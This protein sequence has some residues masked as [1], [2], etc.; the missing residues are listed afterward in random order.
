MHRRDQIDHAI[1]LAEDGR[2]PTEVARITGVPRSTVRDWLQGAVPLNAIRSMD[3]EC[4]R[5]RRPTHE[6]SAL[7][8]EYVYVLGLY[9]GDGCISAH[10]R[11][12]YRLRIFL[13]AEYPGII[14]ACEA[15]IHRLCPKNKV[16]RLPGSGGYPNSSPGSNVQISA[17]SRSWPCL[18]PQHGPGRKHERPIRLVDWQRSL[19]ETYPEA[20]LRGLIHSDGCRFI[21]TGRAWRHPRYAF[22]NRSAD[23]CRIFCDACDVLGLHWTTAPRTVYVSRKADVARLDEFIGPKA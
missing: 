22:N 14:D 4:G 3:G 5:C 20:L 19:L 6:F 7:P 23:I 8:V 16:A 15:A 18:F 1:R 2:T 10:P 9:L 17:Y 11:G 13:D 12:V 21:N